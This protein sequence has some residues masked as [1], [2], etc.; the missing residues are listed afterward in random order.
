MMSEDVETASAIARG[1]F[2]GR[3]KHVETLPLGTPCPNCATPLEGKWCYACGQLGEDFHRSARKLLSESLNEFFDLDNRLWSTLPDLVIRPGRLTR[4][5]LDG[6][7]APQVPPLR[8]F[9]VVLVALFLVGLNVGGRA[10]S[11]VIVPG[12]KAEMLKQ[13]Q[14][15]KNMSAEDKREV[16]KDINV[17][18]G[19]RKPS[20]LATW[21]TQRIRYAVAHQSEFWQQVQNWAE[22]FA[23]LMLPLSA[24]LLSLL[25]AFQ[26]RFF[27]FDHIIFSMHSLSFM[28]LL[29]TAAF[30]WD[31]YIPFKLGDLAA[32]VAPVHLFAHMRG[33]YGTS[34]FGTLFRMAFL[35]IGSVIGATFIVLGLF[36]VVLSAV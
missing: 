4:A 18:F 10:P 12:T 8:L 30:L 14:A 17:S 20:A 9:L 1:G 6:H 13:V 22:R 27:L 16:A 32:I 35:F 31:H 24:T 7:R 33:V 19:E 15:N 2:L 11:N 36:W 5:Y 29:L 3:G 34:A 28:C 25:F 23:F 26:R 21:L